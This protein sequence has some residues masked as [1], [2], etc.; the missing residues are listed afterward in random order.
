M[1]Y[2]VEQKRAQGYSCIK[3]GHTKFGN[4]RQWFYKRCKKCNYDESATVNTISHG[5][6]RKLQSVFELAYRIVLRK[7]G[8][9]TRELA[10][11]LGC[12]QKTAWNGKQNF[13]LQ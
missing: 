3:C 11:E 7:K 1:Q 12:Q 4:G 8:M 13:N 6:N 10:K 5:V 2:L 9:S